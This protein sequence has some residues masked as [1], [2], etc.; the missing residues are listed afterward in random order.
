[1][2]LEKFNTL[3]SGDIFILKDFQTI[4]EFGDDKTFQIEEVNRFTN[5]DQN[6]EIL[7]LKFE[8]KIDDQEDTSQMAILIRRINNDFDIRVI[9]Q[10]ETALLKDFWLDDNFEDPT[11]FFTEDHEFNDDFQTFLGSDE[12]DPL[13]Y[14]LK[15]PYPFF[16]MV[17]EDDYNV[18]VCEYST[19]EV[20]DPF[21]A[22]HCFIEWYFEQDEESFLSVWYGWD[23]TESEID[24]M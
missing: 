8:I 10:C 5:S 24:F 6:F 16:D 12:E 9:K 4:E 23:I 17:D 1:M 2:N 11:P 7:L 15:S 22:R 14:T 3:K 19:D 18:A 20:E 13:T 21:W